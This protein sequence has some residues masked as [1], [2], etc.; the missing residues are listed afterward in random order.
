[1][2][3][4]RIG[5]GRSDEEGGSSGAAP[6]PLCSRSAKRVCTALMGSEQPQTCESR[7]EHAAFTP[8]RLHMERSSPASN[9]GIVTGR[10]HAPN[11]AGGAAGGGWCEREAGG[12]K[13]KGGEGWAGREGA[14]SLL[15]SPPGGVSSSSSYHIAE[16][17][18]GT[19]ASRAT[20]TKPGQTKAVADFFA[21][22]RKKRGSKTYSLY[23]PGRPAAHSVR[24]CE[25]CVLSV[26][27]GGGVLGLCTAC[28]QPFLSHRTH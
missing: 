18:V 12:Q 13:A 14:V 8:H 3:C 19:A 7:W 11:A 16:G 26:K 4:V 9:S 20:A 17:C 25:V 15:S 22:S 23:G 2:C 28:Q 1:M 5:L 21:T 10:V 24:L 27:R 6:W